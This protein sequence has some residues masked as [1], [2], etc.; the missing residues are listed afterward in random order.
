MLRHGPCR[1]ASRRSCPWARSTVRLRH[2]ECCG[3]V[4]LR[5]VDRI[6][7]LDFRAACDEAR[8]LHD[9]PGMKKLLVLLSLPFATVA[10]PTFAQSDVM[11]VTESEMQ[12][13]P[14]STAEARVGEL[15]QAYQDVNLRAPRAGVVVSGLLIPGGMLTMVGG[16][17]ANSCFLT[18]ETNCRNR[19]GNV[20]IGVGAAAMVGGIVGMVVSSV[21]LKRAK[22]KRRRIQREM[23]QLQ[24]ALP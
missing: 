16:A 15:E 8:L 12:M 4:T 20:T 10:A 7:V 6:D 14:A 17:I 22:D 13:M 1:A 9:K 24:R 2:R 5:T 18:S 3:W 23:E 11:V 21:R 19:R